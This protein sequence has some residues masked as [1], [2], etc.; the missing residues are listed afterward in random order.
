MIV[1]LMHEIARV[2]G[3]QYQT[4]V[5]VLEYASLQFARPSARP[6]CY[7]VFDCHIDIPPISREVANS[8]AFKTGRI[9]SSGGR[10]VAAAA[11]RSTD[12]NYGSLGQPVA[13]GE[14]TARR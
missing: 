7:C 13:S 4:A 2:T 11:A 3:G 5:E 10:A 8:F 14:R 9:P 12:L 1:E 6:A